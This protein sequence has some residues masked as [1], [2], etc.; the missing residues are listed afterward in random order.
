MFG[1][2][3][4][5]A[6]R[7]QGGPPRMIVGAALIEIHVHGSQSL[8]QKRG[9]VRSIV[10]RVRNRFNLSVAEVGGQDTWQRA[11][12][13]LGAVGSDERVLRRALEGAID[14]IEQLHL[15][16]VLGSEIEILELPHEQPLD[17]DEGTWEERV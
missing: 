3:D 14:F 8:K 15:A 2:F 6:A 10:Q 12:L 16:E 17:V 4:A 1:A 13:A 5:R 7:E 11:L 9:V